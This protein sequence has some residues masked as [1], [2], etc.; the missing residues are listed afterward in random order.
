MIFL[1][2]THQQIQTTHHLQNVQPG[3]H[4]STPTVESNLGNQVKKALDSS[5]FIGHFDFFY[6]IML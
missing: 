6:L 1:Q 2:P 4:D 3:Y 5:Q